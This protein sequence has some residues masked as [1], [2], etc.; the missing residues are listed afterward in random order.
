M[1]VTKHISLDDDSIEKMK[2]YMEKH[3]GNFGNALREI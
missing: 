3:G 2:P 1:N